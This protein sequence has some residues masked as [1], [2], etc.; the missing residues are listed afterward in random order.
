MFCIPAA[1]RE[2]VSVLLL[3][4]PANLG[5]ACHAPFNNALQELRSLIAIMFSFLATLFPCLTITA[6]YRQSVALPSH[7]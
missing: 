7:R 4:S 1:K 3:R 6:C 2:S 5:Y